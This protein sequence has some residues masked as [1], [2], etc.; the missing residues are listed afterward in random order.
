MRRRKLLV[1]LAGLAVVVAIWGIASSCATPDPTGAALR[2]NF[3]RIAMGG[4]G[5][6]AELVSILGPPGDYTTGPTTTGMDR[7]RAEV[8]YEYLLGLPADYWKTRYRVGDHRVHEGRLRNPRVPNGSKIVSRDTRQPPVACQAPVAP[9][10]PVIGGGMRRRT[11][12]VALVGMAVVTA[13]GAVV[14]WLRTDSITR[15]NY[16]SIKEGMSRT[17]V[18][19]ILG[20][21]GINRVVL[22]RFDREGFDIDEDNRA[23]KDSLYY[24][25]L[26]EDAPDSLLW[27]GNAGVIGVHFQD[28]RAVTKA[29]VPRMALRKRLLGWLERW[30]FGDL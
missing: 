18:E 11:L 24:Y 9:L 30:W 22:D 12:L 19:T 13:V 10:V 23:W 8:P 15:S 3:H 6:Q 29:W 2:K 14:L 28:N 7:E 26:F 1:A 25:P 27:I 4:V 20:P 17:E 21:P 16:D 5:S